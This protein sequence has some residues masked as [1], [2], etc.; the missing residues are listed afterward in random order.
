MK[1][2][3]KK[4]KKKKKTLRKHAYSKILKISPPKTESFQ[5]KNS[6]NFH[7]SAQKH[8]LLVLVRTASAIPQSVSTICVFEQ[9]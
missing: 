1:Q 2:I 9:K 4:K 8:R 7:I 5:V 3:K 6:D